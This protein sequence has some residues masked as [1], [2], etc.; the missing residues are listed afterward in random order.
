M[1]NSISKKLIRDYIYFTETLEDTMDISSEAEREFREALQSESPEALE[2]LAVPKGA[3]KKEKEEPE[4]VKFDD[5]DF[6]KLFRKLAVK[7]HP[8]KIQDAT[9][10]EVSFLK[11]CYEDI[12]LANDT[13]D[14]GLLL[15]VALELEVEI[16]DLSDE[17]LQNIQENIES[18][19]TKIKKYEESMAYKWFTLNDT[20]IKQKYLQTCAD[21]F[22]NSLKN[23]LT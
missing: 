11:K 1:I 10:R 17:Q 16:G 14:W 22:K 3:A 23:R 13:Y 18:L 7:C 9:E 2:A 20:A 6:K 5:K 4:A 12:N 21:I 19:K 8:D 15:K